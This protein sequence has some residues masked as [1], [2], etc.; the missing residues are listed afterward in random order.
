MGS[1]LQ[2]YLFIL[3]MM[4]IHIYK[5]CTICIF[6]KLYIHSQKKQNI[7]K[8]VSFIQCFQKKKKK[9]KQKKNT[10][11]CQSFTLS[12]VATFCFSALTKMRN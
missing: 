7:N 3:K 2:F 10:G 8:L 12:E 11:T 4:K 5:K 6:G 9:K 1:V